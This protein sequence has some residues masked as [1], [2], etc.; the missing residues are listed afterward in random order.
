ML[1]FNIITYVVP[2]YVRVHYNNTNTCLKSDSNSGEYREKAAAMKCSNFISSY[3]M[4]WSTEPNICAK[5]CKIGF[6]ILK[7]KPTGYTNFSNLFFGIKLYMFR[8][9]HLSIIRGFSLYT[10]LASRIRTEFHPD[11]ARKL[12]AN[13][14]DINHCCMYSDKFMM[15]DGETVRNM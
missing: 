6:W 11:P 7:I 1:S 2:M 14:Y 4:I 15:M 9:I 13:L 10:Q 8:T 12:L 3:S 5:K